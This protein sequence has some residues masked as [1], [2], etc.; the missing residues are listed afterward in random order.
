MRFITARARILFASDQTP[1]AERCA[2]R[3]TCAH[4]GGRARWGG[5]MLMVSLASRQALIQ[6]RA[7]L[8]DCARADDSLIVGSDG[9]G[10]DPT[11]GAAPAAAQPQVEQEPPESDFQA[12]AMRACAIVLA[13]RLIAIPRKAGHARA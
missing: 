6:S 13:P 11:T 9:K 10:G 7:R 5:H 3:S 12:R 2:P 1:R 8:L 4:A